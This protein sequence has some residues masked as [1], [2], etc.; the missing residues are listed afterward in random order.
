MDGRVVVS[1]AHIKETK[2]NITEVIE[3]L[4]KNE[5]RYIRLDRADALARVRERILIAEKWATHPP[6][7]SPSGI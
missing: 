6:S 4:K 7:P 3:A 2:M 5:Q 1:V